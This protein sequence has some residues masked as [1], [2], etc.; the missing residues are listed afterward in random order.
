MLLTNTS[1]QEIIFS[2]TPLINDSMC[3][4]ALSLQMINKLIYLNLLLGRVL[5]FSNMIS[6]PNFDKRTAWSHIA[7]SAVTSISHELGNN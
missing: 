7:A 2:I 6:I 4:I 5:K 3:A 1:N